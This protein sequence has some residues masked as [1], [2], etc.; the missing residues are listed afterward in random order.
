MF[1][2]WMPHSPPSLPEE[3][4]LESCVSRIQQHVLTQS[5]NLEY[6]AMRMN[7]P[8]WRIR[9][10][11]E[12]LLSIFINVTELIESAFKA[13][14]D[15][16]KAIGVPVFTEY[17]SSFTNVLDDLLQ[18]AQSSDF[19]KVAKLFDACS[20]LKTN[21]LRFR[22]RPDEPDEKYKYTFSNVTLTDVLVM[23][24]EVSGQPIFTVPFQ[25][26]LNE[27]QELRDEYV[28]LARLLKK[29]RVITEQMY[30]SL[31]VPFGLREDG[32]V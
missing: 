13:G 12:S 8:T 1:Q 31:P 28:A 30:D 27:D 26:M 3:S 24:H 18:I 10:E 22:I 19:A 11:G 16:E 2:V 29:R 32:G 20:L 7:D 15:E 21:N 14:L 17:S 9:H 6:L 4:L 5:E 25:S 23:N